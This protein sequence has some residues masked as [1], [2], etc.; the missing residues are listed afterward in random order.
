MQINHGV[1]HVS[2]S[3]QNLDGGKFGAAVQQMSGEAV[4]ERVRVDGLGDAA[5]RVASRQACQTAF[6]VI[7]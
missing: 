6:A 4:A 3:Q 5:R 2:V 1:A 7:G